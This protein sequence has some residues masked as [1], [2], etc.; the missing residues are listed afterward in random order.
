MFGADVF[1]IEDEPRARL[2]VVLRPRPEDWL[3]DDLVRYRSGGIDILVSL[4]EPREAEW[5]GL[6]FEETLAR[7]AGME[8]LNYP[9]RDGRVPIDVADFRT[10]VSGLAHRLRIGNGVGVHCQGSI[11]R[12]T[13][14]AAWTLIHLGWKPDAA[15]EAIHQARGCDVPDTREQYQWILNYEA[16]P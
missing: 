8:F 11:G 3:E 4:L 13:V 6:S 7:E 12:S 2:A 15:I 14:T 16:Q 9:I 1:W 5:L 10:F